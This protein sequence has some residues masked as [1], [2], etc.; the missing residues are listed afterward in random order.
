MKSAIGALQERRDAY[1]PIWAIG[2]PQ[3]AAPKNN[4]RALNRWRSSLKH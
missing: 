4:K 3:M 1:N 2:T